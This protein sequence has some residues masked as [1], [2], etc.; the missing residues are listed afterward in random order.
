MGLERRSWLTACLRLASYR[1]KIGRGEVCGLEVVDVDE[2]LF[3]M[4]LFPVCRRCCCPLLLEAF[5]RFV[6]FD[7]N[8]EFLVDLNIVVGC[9]E[10]VE[11]DGESS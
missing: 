8:S 1:V 2:D 11:V 4:L 7:C 10:A 9:C 3:L 6:F 5:F